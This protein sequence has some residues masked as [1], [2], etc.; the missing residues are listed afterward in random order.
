MDWVTA[1]E[2][3]C[4]TKMSIT[5]R[6]ALTYLRWRSWWCQLGPNR[7]QGTQIEPELQGSNP[8]EFTVLGAGG[9]GIAPA[10][11]GCG[12]RGARSRLVLCSPIS[13]HRIA[14]NWLHAMLTKAY[15][16]P[17]SVLLIEWA[18]NGLLRY[19][20]PERTLR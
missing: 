10:P 20:L 15:P 4:C 14:A 18:V 12:A 8:H 5:R 9:T 7:G 3:R 13:F 1:T 11:C 6:V 17:W 19:G 16:Q 2:A